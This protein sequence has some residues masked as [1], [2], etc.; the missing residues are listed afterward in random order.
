MDNIII[1]NLDLQAR[2]G[3]TAEERAQPQRLLVT[4]ELSLNLDAAGRS[5]ALDATVDYAAVADL[6]RETVAR[7]ERLLV[8]AVAHDVATA[9]LGLDQISAVTVEIRKFSVPGSEYVAVRITR[10]KE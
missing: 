4:I 9:V 5:D 6:A 10:K 3:V 7:R 2:V 8:E 1:R